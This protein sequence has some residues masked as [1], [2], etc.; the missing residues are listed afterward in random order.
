M[1]YIENCKNYKQQIINNFEPARL[2]EDVFSEDQLAELML[3]QFQ[4]AKRLKW[5]ATSSNMQPVV[6]IS[7]VARIDWLRDFMH[8]QI[9]D[10]ANIHTGNYYITTQ[11]HDAHCDLLTQD[12]CDHDDDF[13]K[14]VPYKSVIIPL[15]ITHNTA[16]HTAFFKQRHIG[17]SVTLDREYDTSQDD[18]MYDI[19]REYP[20]FYDV[21]GTITTYNEIEQHEDFEFPHLSNENM[22][23]LEIESV[24]RFLPGS[25]MIFDACQVHATAQYKRLPPMWDRWLKNGINIQFYRTPEQCLT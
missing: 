15:G 6:N 21:D 17:Y 19:A 3:F 9:G 22:R 8:E 2:V 12:E 1:T 13:N 14:L 25:I 10:Y 20:D 7:R 16:A 24:H 11:P 4:N 5:T 23:G 18:S